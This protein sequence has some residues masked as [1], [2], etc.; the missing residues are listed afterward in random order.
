M[1]TEGERHLTADATSRALPAQRTA[2]F[3]PGSA[4]KPLPNPPAKGRVPDRAGGVIC[5]KHFLFGIKKNRDASCFIRLYER[6]NP[7]SLKI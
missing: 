7:L 1:P 6:G 5:R 4:V 2:S 3:M